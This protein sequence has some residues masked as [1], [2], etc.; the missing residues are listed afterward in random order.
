MIGGG[1]LIQDASGD[2][3]RFLAVPNAA[4]THG[5]AAAGASHAAV[6]TAAAAG[7]LGSP[8]AKR[9]F[10]RVCT[11]SLGLA[12]SAAPRCVCPASARDLVV[13]TSPSARGSSRRSTPRKPGDRDAVAIATPPPSSSL[14]ADADEAPSGASGSSLWG[15][16]WQIVGPAGEP[17]SVTDEREGNRG[18][19]MPGQVE[20]AGNMK[21]HFLLDELQMQACT[22]WID[23]KWPER[24]G[25]YDRDKW[26]ALSKDLET[27]PM[28]FCIDRYEYPNKKG[29]YPIVLVSWYEARDHCA[30]AGKR[31]CTEDEWTYACE[32]DEAT[33]YPNGDGYTRDYEACLEDRPWKQFHAEA[34]NPRGGENARKE[35][36]RLW[37]GYPSGDRPL[38]KSKAGVYDLT[39]NIDEW[40][41]SATATERQSTLKGGYWGP[42]R[43]RCRPAT[44]AHDEQHVFYQ[45]GFRC[46]ADPG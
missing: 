34:Y 37:Q 30:D 27:K 5:R 7:V 35:I 15:H 10:G 22:D 31:L 8:A 41:R 45:Q 33:P 20:V 32:G 36:D 21:Q 16:S 39:G 40:T 46:C 9:T 18:A 12:G 29:E 42:V 13:G 25:A 14:I 3:E 11:S 4:L 2:R 1:T 38:C 44:K 23:R 43:T 26:L 19:C 24:C 17:T 28:H 6:V